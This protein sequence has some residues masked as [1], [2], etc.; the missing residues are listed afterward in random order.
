[1]TFIKKYAPVVVFA[2][3]R[4]FQLTKTIESLK[5]NIYADSTDLI[6]YSDGPKDDDSIESV[7]CVRDYI[8]RIDGFLSVTIYKQDKNLG[9]ADSIVLGVTETIEK[10]GKVIV[11]EDDLVTTQTFLEFMNSALDYYEHD[12]QVMQI[13]GYFPF[14]TNSFLPET[15]FLN[16]VTSTGWATWQR[17]WKYFHREG[18]I[19]LNK[20]TKDDIYKFN[21]DGKLDIYSDLIFNIKGENRTW[22]IFWDLCVYINNGLVLYSNKSKTLNTGFD[23]SGDVCN[24]IKLPQ[25][26]END[27]H[28]KYLTNIFTVNKYAY[29]IYSD[30]MNKYFNNSFTIRAIAKYILI[31][32]LG[33]NRFTIKKFLKKIHKLKT[34]FLK[35]NN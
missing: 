27:N 5:D 1:M 35:L 14:T 24:P 17:S 19:F 33:I 16:H 31:N 6:I 11:L 4:L 7:Q 30:L 32:L 15:F 29:L 10:Y 13:S 25:S 2:Y 28:I 34:K 21:L 22:R 26:I 23:G 12:N 20:F 3:N 9:L 18:E 8:D